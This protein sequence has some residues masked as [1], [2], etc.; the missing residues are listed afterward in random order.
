LFLKKINNFI[1][2]ITEYFLFLFKY[3]NQYLYSNTNFLEKYYVRNEYIW[4]DGFL[5]DFLQKKVV[6]L[7]LRQFVIFTGFLF[8]E[9]YVFENIVY[10]Y[11]DYLLWPAHYYSIF[12]VTNIS[13]MLIS[14][15]YVFVCLLYVFILV[16]SLIFL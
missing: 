12:E 8:S 16:H 9:R 15:L 13:E 10:F 7:W 3:V 6:D 1:F 5:F 4:Q 11:L 2:S 14:I